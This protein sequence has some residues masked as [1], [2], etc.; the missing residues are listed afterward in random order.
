MTE[1]VVVV[2]ILLPL[3]VKIPEVLLFGE[4]TFRKCSSSFVGELKDLWQAKQ[5]NS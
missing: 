3:P 4:W 5:V 1:G 2:P